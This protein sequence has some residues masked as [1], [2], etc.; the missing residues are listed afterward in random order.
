MQRKTGARGLRTILENVL[1]ETMYEL[2]SLRNVQKVI[3]DE[4][5]ILGE[6]K[7]YVLYG[8]SSS[9]DDARLAAVEERRPTGSD[10][11]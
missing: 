10:H 8:T 11:H 4:Q 5:V 6:S 9:Q 7:P 2:P 3:V 1:L